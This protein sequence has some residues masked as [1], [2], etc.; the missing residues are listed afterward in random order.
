MTARPFWCGSLLDAR[1]D[2]SVPY[3]LAS[4][5][6]SKTS[7][8]SLEGPAQGLKCIPIS[9]DGRR[10]FAIRRRATT[11]ALTSVQAV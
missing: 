11:G 5:M 6:L 8:S 7:A 1:Q 3:F 2:F 4:P 10:D 9:P